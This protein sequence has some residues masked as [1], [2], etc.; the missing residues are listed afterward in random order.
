MVVGLGKSWVSLKTKNRGNDEGKLEGVRWI[1][2]KGMPCSD[3]GLVWGWMDE[4][5]MVQIG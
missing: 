2:A 4:I 5:Q 1:K 3:D